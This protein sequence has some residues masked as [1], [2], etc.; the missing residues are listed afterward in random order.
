MRAA[1]WLAMLGLL[2]LPA[3]GAEDPPNDRL[4]A[5]IDP[6]FRGHFERAG[7]GFGCVIPP[8]PGVT[9]ARVAEA[10]DLPCLFVGPLSLGGEAAMP[11]RLLGSPN[12]SLAGPNGAE[13][14]VF[15]FRRA[16]DS[17]Y[18]VASI[19]HGRIVALQLTG[20]IATVE[21]VPAEFSFNR[22]RLGATTD[23]VR[24]VLG[25]AKHV[26]PVPTIE[27]ELWS[28][29]PWTFSF[30]MTEQRVSSIRICHPPFC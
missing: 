14:Q 4:P 25:P 6:G 15:F 29:S 30:E 21:Q 22:L 16:A 23:T 10:G 13:A 28:Y 12:Q 3:A 20:P 1:R 8:Q 24:A 9:G 19:W 7:A 2:G 18:L 11:A 5:P 27:A 17:P 26:V